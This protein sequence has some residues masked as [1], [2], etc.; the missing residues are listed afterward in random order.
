MDQATR[1][2]KKVVFAPRAGDARIAAQPPQPHGHKLNL[3]PD[4]TSLVG[5]SQETSGTTPKTVIPVNWG[6]PGRPSKFGGPQLQLPPGF[7]ELRKGKSVYTPELGE[8]FIEEYYNTGGSITRAAYRLKVKYTS[9]LEWKSTIPLFAQALDEV[10]QIIRD[11]I[12]AQFMERV[13]NTWEPNPAWKFKYF[14]KHFPDY[15]ETKKTMKVTFSLKDSLIRPDVID[16]EVVKPKQ[17]E[18][19]ADATGPEQPMES[20]PNTV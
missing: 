7:K 2:G 13:L 17:L 4:T 10:D 14:N 12:H 1:I 5:D 15:S 11:E 20:P 8:Q 9:A 18:S 19:G 3:G 16:G 6:K